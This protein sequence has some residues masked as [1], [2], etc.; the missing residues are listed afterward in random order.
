MATSASA[1]TLQIDAIAPPAW[2]AASATQTGTV[3]STRVQATTTRLPWNGTFNDETG[4]AYTNVAFGSLAQP[5]GTTGD[6]FNQAVRPGDVFDLAIT[7]LDPILNP[8]FYI[9]DIDLIGATVG[10]EPGWSDIKLTADGVLSGNTLGTTSG[11]LQ[12]TPGASAAV[13]YMGSFDSGAT[14]TFGWDFSA[15]ATTGGENIALAIGTLSGG[16]TPPSPIPIPASGLLLGTAL[17]GVA[18]LRPRRK[19]RA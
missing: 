11:A 12:G 4:S 5:D 15:V 16:V 6:A 14:F 19:T 3:G 8:I 13:Q 17:I 7:F 1:A 9:V 2:D 10:I 18:G